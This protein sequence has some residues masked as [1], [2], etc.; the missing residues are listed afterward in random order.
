MVSQY[1]P[2][3]NSLET[4]EELLDRICV[5]LGGRCVEEKFF[6]EVTTG[7]Y[8]DLNKAYDV[9]FNIV[10]R[11]GMSERIG[12]VGYTYDEFV[13]KYRFIFLIS[14]IILNP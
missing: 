1:L 8:D 10:A 13:K 9:A 11:L 3:E 2:N 4:K 14:V 5:I 6:K 12:Y 7:A